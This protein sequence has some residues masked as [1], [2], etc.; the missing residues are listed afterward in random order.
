MANIITLVDENSA[1]VDFHE[2]GMAAADG[3]LVL[4]DPLQ[5]FEAPKL[6]TRA[7]TT[8]GKGPAAVIKA[9]NRLDHTI[10]DPDDGVT[11]RKLACYRCWVMPITGVTI[12]DLWHITNLE[13]SSFPNSGEDP[14]DKLGMF[15]KGIF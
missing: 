15:L 1:N 11:P 8:V 13:M 2:L 4:S 9:V 3:R 6:L 10:I 14:E 12:A 7:V 5:P